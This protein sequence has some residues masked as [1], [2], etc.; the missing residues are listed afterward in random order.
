MSKL[1]LLDAL[2]LSCVLVVGGTAIAAAGVGELDAGDRQPAASPQPMRVAQRPEVRKSTKTMKSSDVPGHKGPRAKKSSEVDRIICEGGEVKTASNGVRGCSC[3]LNVTRTVVAKNHFRCE[4]PQVRKS[5]KTMDASDL[6][7]HKG[8][9][10][11]KS[12]DVEKAPGSTGRPIPHQTGPG[13]PVKQCGDM[14]SVTRLA[15]L[16]RAGGKLT[17]Q[18]GWALEVKKRYPG[19]WGNWNNARDRKT[20]CQFAGTWNCTA[21]AR[22]CPP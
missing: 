14:V 12:S 8:P 4:R 11:K 13:K 3:G 22:P 5:S 6:P 9:R 7:G 19:G 1:R 18:A 10:A 2:A 15:A 20:G 16:T 17:A 21:T